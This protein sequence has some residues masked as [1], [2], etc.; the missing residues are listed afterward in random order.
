MRSGST[1]TSTATARTSSPDEMV[2]AIETMAEAHEI[3]AAAAAMRNLAAEEIAG[4]E[5]GKGVGAA[6]RGAGAPPAGVPVPGRRR[7]S[8]AEAAQELAGASS[9]TGATAA[10]GGRARRL[11]V[12][13]SISRTAVVRYQELLQRGKPGASL[14]RA[15]GAAKTAAAATAGAATAAAPRTAARR[16]RRQP[17]WSAAA[18]WRFCTLGTAF[19]A[20]A[21]QPGVDCCVAF[22]DDIAVAVQPGNSAALPRHAGRA[23]RPALPGYAAG[24]GRVPPRVAVRGAPGR[25]APPASHSRKSDDGS[26]LMRVGDRITPVSVELHGGLHRSVDTL[27]AACQTATRIKWAWRKHLSVALLS[28]RVGQVLAGVHLLD[29]WATGGPYGAHRYTDICRRN[30]SLVYDAPDLRG[31]AGRRI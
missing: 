17:W 1:Q 12:R 28:A 3:I 30:S 6:P 16:T 9:G 10:G 31:G 14:P 22:A 19:A 4:D 2:D 23:A 26:P 11:R 13:G 27:L 25:N 18:R 24:H 8:S 15:S 7:E 5:D 29:K 20:V 21:L